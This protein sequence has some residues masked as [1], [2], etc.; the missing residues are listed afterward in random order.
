MIGK[1][2]LFW[3]VDA[4]HFK[5][6]I[7][8]FCRK[9]A[10]HPSCAA[11]RRIERRENRLCFEWYSPGKESPRG[12]IIPKTRSRPSGKCMKLGMLWKEYANVE[13]NVVGTIP[14]KKSMSNR[15]IDGAYHTTTKFRGSRYTQFPTRCPW[16]RRGRC[17][18][19]HVTPL[20]CPWDG[21]PKHAVLVDKK[22]DESFFLPSREQCDCELSEE[23]WYGIQILVVW[24]YSI[25]TVKNYLRARRV[26]R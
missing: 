21:Q 15:M 23:E 16:C 22:G 18:R 8:A 25:I 3:F 5:V 17:I 14:V 19:F 26:D 1:R 4:W 10:Q 6:K 20:D 7:W 11:Y 24:E 9:M 12:I 2:L 13:S